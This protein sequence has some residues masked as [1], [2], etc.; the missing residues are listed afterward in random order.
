MQDANDVGTKNSVE[1]RH[2]KQVGLPERVTTHGTYYGHY[3]TINQHGKNLKINVEN[4]W[5]PVDQYIYGP[6]VNSIFNHPHPQSQPHQ[7]SGGM[8]SEKGLVFGGSIGLQE[9]MLKYSSG[10]RG[11]GKDGSRLGKDNEVIKESSGR[12]DKSSRS[13]ERRRMVAEFYANDAPKLCDHV[14]LDRNNHRMRPCTPLESYVSTGSD[15]VCS[16]KVGI[17]IKTK[18]G[19]LRRKSSS[20]RTSLFPSS[21][22]IKYEFADTE[23]GSEPYLGQKGEDVPLLC[24]RVFRK[25]KGEFQSPRNVFLNGRGGASN[26]TCLY[27]FE[28]SVG[29]RVRI[30]LF[31]VSFGD[32][33]TCTTESDGHTGRAK[34]TPSEAVPDGRVGELRRYDVPYKDVKI[35]LGCF[36]DNT[37]SSY[38]FP[39]TFALNSRTMELTRLNV[40]DVHNDVRTDPYQHDDNQKIDP[41]KEWKHKVSQEEDEEAGEPEEEGSDEKDT[42]S[43][44]SAAKEQVDP[45]KVFQCTVDTDGR[46]QERAAEVK[47][48]KCRGTTIWMRCVFA[49]DAVEVLDLD[50]G[51]MK[52]VPSNKLYGAT[53]F[54]RNLPVYPMTVKNSGLIIEHLQDLRS[55]KRFLKKLFV[56][57]PYIYDGVKLMKLEHKPLA[58]STRRPK[59]KSSSARENEA[60]I[61]RKKWTEE[62]S[63][64]LLRPPSTPSLPTTTSSW[65][66]IWRART[67]LTKVFYQHLLDSM[68]KDIDI[69]PLHGVYIGEEEAI[70]GG[71][72][73]GENRG[74]VAVEA[75]NQ[76]NGDGG[77]RV[78][79][80]AAT[81]G[82]ARD[83]KEAGICIRVYGAGWMIPEFG[84]SVLVLSLLWSNRG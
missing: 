63:R 7:V 55:A 41:V 34:C 70:R 28:A 5:N 13:N 14:S 11:K 81:S 35:P 61:K 17:L 30:D 4:V 27:R 83:A 3:G 23:L 8:G 69:Y 46:A 59:R 32:S 1:N 36:C 24:S 71:A 53:G 64:L 73:S 12:R 40:S 42:E 49:L 57:K 19:I 51:S 16:Y 29:E 25:R 80:L 79:H 2:R 66:N 21:F 75:G 43:G 22:G 54:I 58:D 45:E 15:L 33:A 50:D 9:K 44:K 68:V 78:D 84:E 20:T 67:N 39:L 74:Q 26:I 65:S 72:Y 6:T 60:E 38:N 48:W 52:M 56:S 62:Q 76:F 37:T 31:N 47:S 77:S 18:L 82:N 10:G